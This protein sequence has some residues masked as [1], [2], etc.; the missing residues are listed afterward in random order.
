MHWQRQSTSNSYANADNMISTKILRSIASE[1]S[2]PSTISSKF[3]DDILS[4][5]LFID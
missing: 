5:S 1:T 2:H 4:Y 3:V